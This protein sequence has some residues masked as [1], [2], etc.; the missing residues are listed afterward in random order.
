MARIQLV[1]A[2]QCFEFDELLDVRSPAEFAEDHIPGAINVPV[3]DN[4][5]RAQV[6][7]LYTQVS[8]F[9][10]RKV[11]A[12]LIA[13]NIAT[14]IE[15]HFMDK[16]RSWRPLV[17]CWRGGQ[18]SGAMAHILSQVGWSVGQLEG[19][20]K[21]YRQ[22]V[23]AELQILPTRFRFRVVCGP[24]GSGKSR[25]L[26]A[27]A[28]YGAQV[29]DLENL[30]NHRGSLLGGLPDSPQPSQKGFETRLWNTLRNFDPAHPV[31]TEAE[32]RK[33]GV[34][35]LP[36]SLL[37]SIRHADCI[38][39]DAGLSARATLLLE[40]Y[41]HFLQHPGVLLEKLDQLASLHSRQTL[42]HWRQLTEQKEWRQLVTELLELHYD[43]AYKRSTHSHFVHF[44][45]AVTVQ[46]SQLDSV[47]LSRTANHLIQAITES[48]N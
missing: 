29:L 28:G 23:R 18:R 41:D 44:G 27:L 22:R 15:Q 17:Y 36:D 37:H 39:L 19:G 1:N 12:A 21:A 10:A 42:E 35:S 9:E 33:I 25:L 38:Q 4:A 26:Q 2:A 16:P 31:F 7:T 47:T 13:H 45:L 6:G 8:P 34:L 3:L 5:Q 48:E 11:G 20:Y 43:P 30:A 32:S 46:L 14:H 40:D 24:T